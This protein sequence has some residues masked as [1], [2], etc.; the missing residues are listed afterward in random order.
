MQKTNIQT[1]MKRLTT[2]LIAAAT[3]LCTISAQEISFTRMAFDNPKINPDNSVT[4]TFSAPNAAKIEIEGGFLPSREVETPWGRSQSTGR[5]TLP[6]SAD[7]IFTFTS[8]PLASDFYTY[9]VYIDGVRVVDPNNVYHL[10]DVANL[11]NYFIIGGGYGDLFEVQ[12]VPHGDVAKV[13]YASPRAGMEQRRLSVYT[14]AGYNPADR[15]TKYPVLYIMHG[16]GGD[17]NAWMDGGRLP[18]VMD[19]LIASGQ[20]ENMIVVVT[21]SNMSQQAA[22]G[23]YADSR[24]RPQLMVPGNMDG[25]FEESFLDIVEFIESRYNVYKDKAHRALAGL[26]MGGFHTVYISANYPDLFDYVCP[27]SAA[28]ND[29]SDT[30]AERDS[31]IYKDFDEKL[32]R[33]F[34]KAPKLYWIACG[35]ADNLMVN[36]KELMAK[37]DAKGYKYEFVETEGGHT[38]QNW[39]NYLTRFVPLLFK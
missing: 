2:L 24:R 4:F 31:Y 7:G 19:N 36:N 38:W 18:Q 8:Q 20:A 10:R 15:K 21:N 23:D 5:V 35:N 16:I 11:N 27:L 3:T 6:K 29:H 34:K 25:Q 1:D 33:Q 9:N 37:M 14:P 32:D 30:Q 26:S 17:E 13:W 28:L 12:D 39:R 22:P